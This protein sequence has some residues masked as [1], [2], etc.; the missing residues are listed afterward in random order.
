MKTFDF[1][2]C[3]WAS[4]A[5]SMIFFKNQRGEIIFFFKIWEGYPRSFFENQTPTSLPPNFSKAQSEARPEEA[6]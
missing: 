1:F 3:Y 6:T 2:D 5:S 4:A